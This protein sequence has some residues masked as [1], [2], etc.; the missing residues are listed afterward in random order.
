MLKR[1]FSPDPFKTFY[2]VFAYILAFAMW[3]AYL[4]YEKNETAYKE[5][6]ELNQIAFQQLNPGMA[7]PGSK[8]WHFVT[9]KYW[10][11]K[12][13]ILTEGAAFIFLLFLGFLAVRGVFKREMQLVQQQHNFLLSV[14][15]ELKSPLSTVKLSLQTLAKRRLEL[16][17]EKMEKLLV[18]SL[19]DIDRLESLVDNILFAAKIERD[20]PGFSN[21]E[22]NVSDIT[23]MA[24]ERFAQNKKAI[25]VHEQITPDVYIHA[26]PIGFTSVVMNLIENAIKYSE[27]KTEVQVTLSDN[28]QQILLSVADGGMGISEKEKLRVFD[29]FYRV[30]NEDTRK[31]KGTGLGLYIVKRFVEIYKGEISITDNKPVGSVFKLSFPKATA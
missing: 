14:T 3:W 20:E 23:Q 12:W 28:G 21:D 24:V 29:K 9:D 13:M 11:Q 1:I 27:P 31:T 15:H 30:G 8:D 5:K 6:L 7:Y 16:E 2:L 19:I 17:P 18:N 25:R 4:L 22:I 26:D 10:R